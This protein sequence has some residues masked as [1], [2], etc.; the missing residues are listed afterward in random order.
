MAMPPVPP[1]Q[2]GIPGCRRRRLAAHR[3]APASEPGTS[4]PVAMPPVLLLQQ[5]L[6]VA[7]GAGRQHIEGPR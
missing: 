1:L 6:L 7:G 3:G 4:G 2:L 5:V